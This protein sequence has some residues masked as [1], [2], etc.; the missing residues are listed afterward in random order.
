MNEIPTLDSLIKWRSQVTEEIERFKV[1]LS[2]L[3]IRLNESNERLE[4]IDKLLEL[5]NKEK[6]ET[7]KFPTYTDNL[8]DGCEVIL[9]EIG[10]PMHIRELHLGLLKKGIPIPGKGNQ[11]N[12]IARLQRSEGRIIRTG[13]GMY[14]LPEFG[15]PEKKPVRKRKK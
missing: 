13:H 11:A 12:V 6:K 8:I 1:E 3:Q 2:H 15:L 9:R 4:L 14:G 7:I 10:K 5:G